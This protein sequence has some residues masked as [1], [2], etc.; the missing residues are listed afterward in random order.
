MVSNW[1]KM[2]AKL[3]VGV[4]KHV[5]ELLLGEIVEDRQLATIACA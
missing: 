3:A 5:M 1:M 4:G 2:V